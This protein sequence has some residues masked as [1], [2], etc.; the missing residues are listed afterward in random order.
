[1]ITYL[2]HYEKELPNTKLSKS[3]SVHCGLFQKHQLNSKIENI[4]I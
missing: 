4:L 1:M 2:L 3:T